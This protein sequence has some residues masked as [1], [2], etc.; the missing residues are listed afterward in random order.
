MSIKE[1]GMALLQERLKEEGYSGKIDSQTLFSVLSES[2]KEEAIKAVLEL[3]E[4]EK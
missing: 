3:L 2:K 1:L 4:A